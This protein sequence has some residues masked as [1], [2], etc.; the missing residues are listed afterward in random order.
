MSS[1]CEV[2]CEILPDYR[3]REYDGAQGDEENKKKAK[4][5]KDAA[6]KKEGDEEE[7]KKDEKKGKAPHQKKLRTETIELRNQEQCLL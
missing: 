7:D 1:L 6:E 2:F 5:A 4:D 3:I